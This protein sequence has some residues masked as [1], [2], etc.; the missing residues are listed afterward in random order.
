MN[1]PGEKRPREETEEKRYDMFFVNVSHLGVEVDSSAS[2]QKGAGESHDNPAP[3]RGNTHWRQCATDCAGLPRGSLSQVDRTGQ[4]GA[5]NKRLCTTHSRKTSGRKTHGRKAYHMHS[6]KTHGRK[7]H[8]AHLITPLTV[9]RTGK[10]HASENART[11]REES[12]SSPTR[13]GVNPRALYNFSR[14]GATSSQEEVIEKPLDLTR[15]NRGG[16][17]SST[18]NAGTR[19]EPTPLTTPTTSLNTSGE[20]QSPRSSNFPPLRT[21]EATRTANGP[22]NTS[23][24]T[25]TGFS[26]S[27]NLLTQAGGLEK[28][29]ANA[30]QHTGH[31]NPNPG[32]LKPAARQP[33]PGPPPATAG[34][35]PAAATGPQPGTQGT[36]ILQP[37]LPQPQIPPPAPAQGEHAQRGPPR[38]EEGSTNVGG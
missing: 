31:H 9:I 26:P 11:E 24:S 5:E 12:N 35:P 25:N 27:R 13:G 1:K 28:N 30:L 10:K 18:N 32:A 4:R 23:A 15:P 20:I 2:L 17:P 7:T 21:G 38:Q 8:N 22:T 33:P 14:Q 37:Q 16:P 3:H 36:L 19:R 6:R 29:L 34:P